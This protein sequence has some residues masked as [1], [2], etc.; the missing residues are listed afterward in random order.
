VDDLKQLV[1]QDPRPV[2]R[3][4]AVWAISKIE[5]EKSKSY[6]ENCLLIENEDIVIEE[7]KNAIDNF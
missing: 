5:G 2:I 3:G 1:K 7:I 4:T 6:L